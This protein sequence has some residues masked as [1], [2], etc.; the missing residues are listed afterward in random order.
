M[1][2]QVESVTESCKAAVERAV[3]RIRRI[4]KSHGVTAE[5]LA[6]IKDELISLAAMDDL[7]SSS[8]FPA[9]GEDSEKPYA[10][11]LL[12]EDDDHR[13]ALYLQACRPGFDVPPHNHTT[14]A[15][16]VGIEGVEENRFYERGDPGAVRT[17][18]HR[19]GPGGGVAFLPDDLHSIHI[20]GTT[21]VRNF[22]MYGLSLD[23]LFEREYWSE[24]DQTWKI[25]PPQDDIIDRRAG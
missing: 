15:C 10:L 25:F 1:L 11:Y 3:E 20:H 9:P 12:S 22:H 13:F 24:K 17:G 7:F 19:V 6:A 2:D 14:W 16:I 8:V 5:A 4:E 21:P 23:R 18:G